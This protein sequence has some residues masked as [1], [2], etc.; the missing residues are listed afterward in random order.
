MDRFTRRDL[1]KLAVAAS[2][3]AAAFSLAPFASAQVKGRVVIIGGGPGGATVAHYIKKNAPQIDVTLVEP[4]KVYT[5]CFFANLYLGGFRTFESLNHSYSGLRALGVNV[6]HAHAT[7]VDTAR[8]TVR[9]SGGESLRYDKLVLSP[10]ID[11][12]W[13]SVPGYSAEAAKSM[14][15]AYLPGAQTQ[16]LKR[17]LDN[18]ENGGV[19]AMVM[20]S[21]IYRCPP[22]PYERM[23]MIAHFLKTNKPK[24]KLIVLDPKRTLVSKG[25]LFKE[26]FDKYYSGIIEHHLTDD[27]DDFAVER[28]DVKTQEIKAKSGMTVK[29]AVANVIP[30]QRAGRIVFRAGVTDGDWC[31]INPGDFSSTKVKDV[32]VLGDASKAGQMPKSGFSANNQAKSVASAIETELAGKRRFPPRYRNTCWSMLAPDDSVKV[33]ANYKADDLSAFEGFI[34]KVGEDAALRKRTF[35]ESLAWYDGITADTFAEGAKPARQKG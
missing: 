21:G 29:A 27:F 35:E 4:S 31:P 19:V 15:H 10:G 22:G 18:M 28:I 30:S 20:P 6:V 3:A 12:K 14:P 32:Y 16:L 26:A 17:Q 33:G 13:E 25:A 7:D 34:S 23:C 1:G 24:S 5:T 2:G 8:K 9:L 11:L